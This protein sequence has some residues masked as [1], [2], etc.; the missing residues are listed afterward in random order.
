MEADEAA[1]PNDIPT[2]GVLEG[3]P[4]PRYPPSQQPTDTSCEPGG[5]AVAGA[6]ASPSDA[7][8]PSSQSSGDDIPLSDRKPEAGDA[9]SG[10][11]APAAATSAADAAPGAAA[12]EAELLTRQASHAEASASGAGAAAQPSGGR[13]ASGKRARSQPVDYAALAGEKR[14]PGS[15]PRERHEPEHRE[16]PARRQPADDGETA[17]TKELR[18]LM[19]RTGG[20]ND[21]GKVCSCA[22]LTDPRSDQLVGTNERRAGQKTGKRALRKALA[23]SACRARVLCV[24][25]NEYLRCFCVFVRIDAGA[26][27]GMLRRKHRF[28][29]APLTG[30]R[31]LPAGG[32]A[33]NSHEPPDG[34]VHSE[35]AA[36]VA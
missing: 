20:V 3:T 6:A 2:D 8:S 22:L 28:L 26:D 24:Q 30:C 4:P 15:A 33:R 21:P 29:R 13:A 16:R 36:R 9:D 19:A 23:C 25:A 32:E 31:F 27:P 10:P 35:G 12:E 1:P 5:S 14:E 17:F 18:Q 7:V 34:P 11:S